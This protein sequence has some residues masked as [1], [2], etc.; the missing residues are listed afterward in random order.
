MRRGV[1][2]ASYFRNI[3]V[4]QLRSFPLG[5]ASSDT[6][7][8]SA[9]AYKTILLHFDDEA[10]A[11]ALID[12]ASRIASDHAAHLIGLFVM[13]PFQL[14]AGQSVGVGIV[15]EFSSLLAKEQIE[16]ME[17]IKKLFEE[18]T[19]NQNYVAEWR[20]ID[21][22]DSPL[23]DTVLQEATIVDLLIVG[24]YTQ[25]YFTQDIITSVLLD[26][27]VPVL[28][29]PK[30]YESIGFG[31]EILIAWDWKNE[32]TRAVGGA[33]PIL[34]SAENVVAHHIRTA[35]DEGVDS[36]SNLQ[37]FS[38]KL[39]RHGIK[40]EMSESV[41]KREDIGSTIFEVA[42]SHG[43]D[44]IVMGAFGHSRIRSLV[45]GNATDYAIENMD[46]PILVWH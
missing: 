20:F 4:S 24:Q 9:M 30:T 39:A 28:L 17:R 10:C 33:L 19:C 35:V 31:K 14:Y 40:V 38:K 5:I 32:A 25:N 29:V 37:E 36:D 41:A 45:L 11:P 13:H 21:E 22:R 42:K 3:D 23:E 12:L 46:I 7:K 44:C 18:K 8:D 16:R 2:A 1:V 34:K 26:S 15:G 27:P 43:A 6:K